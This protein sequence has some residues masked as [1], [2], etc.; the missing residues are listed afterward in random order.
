MGSVLARG[1][2]IRK[3][4]PSSQQLSGVIKGGPIRRWVGITP[5]ETYEARRDLI[6]TRVLARRF[7][8]DTGL[9]VESRFEGV[10]K[11]DKYSASKTALKDALMTGDIEAAVEAKN[12]LLEMGLSLKSIKASVR[13][14][15]PVRIGMKTNDTTQKDFMR[16]M[17]KH[18]PS[19][20]HRVQRVQN[21]YTYSARAIGL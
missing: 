15:Q 7:G 19:E 10:F 20:V 16:W 6:R 3:G 13:S 18:N 1:R 5:F 4:N 12:D 8:K 21:R 11:P 9:D 14:G 2:R 17:Y